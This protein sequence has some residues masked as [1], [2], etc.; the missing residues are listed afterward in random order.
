M[1]INVTF[2]YMTIFCVIF[3]FFV[4]ANVSKTE[5]FFKLITIDTIDVAR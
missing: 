2:L 3:A 5:N 4:A 1:R